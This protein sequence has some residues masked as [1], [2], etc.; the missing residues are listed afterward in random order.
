M[1]ISNREKIMLCILGII[2]VGF[3]YYRFLY[4]FQTEMIEKK[5]KQES[6]I[7]QKYAETME[8]IKSM[9]DR[10]SDVKILKA[11]INDES[12]SFYPIISEEHII[13]ELDKLLEENGLDGGITFKPIISDSIEDSKKEIVSLGESS[14]QPIAD[15]YK[16]ITNDTEKVQQDTKLDT[17]S[18]NSQINNPNNNTNETNNSSNAKA[19]S[20]S[21]GKVKNTT[22]YLKCEIKFNGNYEG[23]DKFLDAIDKNQRKIV[24]NSIKISEDTLDSV[25]G[26]IN[27][28]IYSVPKITDELQEYLK[29][30]LNNTY[31]KSVPFSN[32]AASGSIDLNKD[33]TD[34]VANVK[35][36][37]SELPTI[38]IGKADDKLRRTYIYADSNSEENVEMI[39][40]QNGDKY[41]Y[42]YKTSK[43]AFPAK[44]NGL[45]VE[46]VPNSKNIVLSL[47]SEPRV[48]D[49]DNSNIKLK[50]TNETDKLV[51]VNIS[52]DDT[53]NPR[54]KIDGDGSNISVNKK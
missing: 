32:G 5:T 41:Y 23:I 21:K 27:L 44:Y 12:I 31:G 54:V 26:T 49:N 25:R 19:K 15:K 47:L 28:E 38:T 29:W 42:K 39:L 4:S 53:D 45:G 52:N 1:K 3:C 36:I 51:E 50:I 30:E 8:T 40:T 16:N 43:G 24:V 13:I 9:E 2:I 34:F 35:P 11:K 48:T 33:T 14:L 6:E 22:Q 46:F 17:S 18:T 37:N 20:D 10:K 7:K